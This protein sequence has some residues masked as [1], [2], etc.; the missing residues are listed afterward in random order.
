MMFTYKDATA[1][2][3][4][5][6]QFQFLILLPS[7]VEMQRADMIFI[8]MMAELLIPADHSWLRQ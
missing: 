6:D 7:D 3:V 1:A 2:V 8:D 5:E 4:E